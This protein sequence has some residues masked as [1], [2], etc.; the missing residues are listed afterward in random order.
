MNECPIDGCTLRT[1]EDQLLCRTHWRQVPKE[2]QEAVWR[3]WKNRQDEWHN[4]G[5]IRL[6][7]AAKAAAIRYVEGLKKA[8]VR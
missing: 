4:Q 8:G 1:G 7:E 6:H 3:T 5:L 2:L